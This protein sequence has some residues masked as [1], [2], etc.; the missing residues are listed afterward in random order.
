MALA[1]HEFCSKDL[2]FQRQVWLVTRSCHFPLL[3]GDSQAEGVGS[4]TDPAV[5]TGTD[6]HL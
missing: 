6:W 1:Q 3:L 4:D 5:C 2:K